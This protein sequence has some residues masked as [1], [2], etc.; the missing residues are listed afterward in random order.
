[1]A[2]KFDELREY[3]EKNPSKLNEY[4]PR[5]LEEI[6]KDDTGEFIKELKYALRDEMMDA[7]KAA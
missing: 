5:V 4:L 6:K 2:E 3:I 1:M 7:V